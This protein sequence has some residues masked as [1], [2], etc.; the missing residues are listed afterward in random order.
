M[1]RSINWFTLLLIVFLFVGY[2]VGLSDGRTLNP[3]NA[4]KNTISIA[5]EIKT[6]KL[7]YTVS[8]KSKYTLLDGRKANVV[9]RTYSNG[10]K[11]VIPVNLNKKR[12]VLNYNSVYNLYNNLGS[13]LRPL[14][15][16]IQVVDYSDPDD[17][18]DKENGQ[19]LYNNTIAVTDEIGG[20]ITFY[21][22]D[23]QLRRL[24]KSKFDRFIDKTIKHEAA[25]VW[26]WNL[27]EETEFSEENKW[28]SACSKDGGYVSGYARD[29][30]KYEGLYA[31]DFA[32]AVSMYL[33]SKSSFERNYPNRAKILNELMR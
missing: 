29:A 32:D 6:N 13:R 15:K 5:K 22:N 17:A 26:D 11:I 1:K 18:R 8:Y 33:R 9:I 16:E 25:H 30:I 21:K 12:Q 19:S 23:F 2:Q 20:I 27:G 10:I 31:E 7:P 24:G 28:K 14:I 3:A 4:N